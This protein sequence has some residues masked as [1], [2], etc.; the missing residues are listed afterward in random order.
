MTRVTF[1]EAA[2]AELVEAARYY[3]TRVEGLGTA[4]LLDVEHTVEQVRATPK[5]FAL[6]GIEV[7]H[8]RLRRFPYS[9]MYVIEP[10]R[11]RIV[12]IAHH[13][14]RPGYWLDRLS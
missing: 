14:R 2:E 5:A 10:D 6:V 11:I 7:R 8:K 9:L 12:A 3:E 13:R 1:H 4:L